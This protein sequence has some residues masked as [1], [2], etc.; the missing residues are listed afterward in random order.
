MDFSTA[1][2][3]DLVAAADPSGRGPAPLLRS[4]AADEAQAT[5]AL[6]FADFLALL[7]T[8]LP[9]GESWPITGKDLPVMPGELEGGDAFAAVPNAALLAAFANA[10]AAAAP[11]TQPAAAGPLSVGLPSNMPLPVST[12]S[13]E[14]A[15]VE[16]PAF[17]PDEAA[18][19]ADPGTPV[20]ADLEAVAMA[21]AEEPLAPLDG[22]ALEVVTAP[23]KSATAP[24][25][26]EAFALERRWQRPAAV[27][28]V[29]PRVATPPQLLAPPS[30]LAAQPSAAA[31]LSTNGESHAVQVVRPSIELPQLSAISL[32]G[33]ESA[34]VAQAEW[35]PTPAHGAATASAASAGP[36]ATPAAPG[37]PVD[38]RAPNWHEAFANRVQWIVDQKIG[39]AHIKLNPPELGAVDVKI[40]LVDDK[41][42][43]QLTTATATARDELAHS[44]PRLRELFT[45]GGL[46]LGGASVHNGRHGH[47][48]GA[49]NGYGSGGEPRASQPFERFSKDRAEASAF[50]PRRSSGRIDVFA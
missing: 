48:A 8:P 5:A 34:G 29:E 26:L 46:E 2:P 39:E 7:T 19:A 20:A 15:A 11:P 12:K 27:S 16:Q 37:A 42:Y 50:A 35:L 21:V 14:P 3:A 44:L 10:G 41:T 17:S 31:A 23:V 25:W 9:A 24:S 13:V 38:T 22:V 30:V 40:S 33:V 4:V 43:V 45:L 49:G 1:L 32:E 18:S 6:P 28:A 36:I 47:Q